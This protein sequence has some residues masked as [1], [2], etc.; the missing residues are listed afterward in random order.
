[1]PYFPFPPRALIAG[2]L[3]PLNLV[4]Q[5]QTVPAP[6]AV[7]PSSN[8]LQNKPVSADLISTDAMDLFRIK[9]INE[10]ALRTP[11]LS[12]TDTGSRSFGDVYSIRGLTSP[13]FFGNPVAT[14]Y[15]DDVPMTD[16]F[17]NVQRLSPLNTVEIRRGPQPLMTGRNA[18]GGL[19]DI[20]TRRPGNSFEGGLDY[21]YGSFN[22][23]SMDAYLMGPVVG[24]QLGFRI[25]GG[26]DNHAGY[27]RNAFTG[28]VVDDQEHW[29]INGGLY[30]K[31]APGWDV[32][33]TASYDEYDDGAPRLTRLDR[34]FGF[35]TT[36]T[37]IKGQQ[38]RRQDSE[39]LRVAYEND[40]IKVLSVTSHRHFG[41]DPYMVDLGFSPAFLGP[42]TL[43]QDMDAW[44]QEFRV[45]NNDKHSNW[46]WN[47]GLFG[48]TSRIDGQRQR[49]F[50]S[51]TSSSNTTFRTVD[52]GFPFLFVPVETITNRFTQFE[53]QRLYKHTLDEKDFAVFAGTSWKGLDPLTFTIGARIDYVQRN[54]V[55]DRTTF[56]KA[57]ITDNTTT[58]IDPTGGFFFFPPTFSTTQS[59]R[60]FR[61]VAPHIDTTDDWS[62]VTPTFGVDWKIN[63]HLLA[64]A[65]TTYGFKP[66]GFNPVADY[67]RFQDFKAEK[68]WSTEV[69]VK[70]EWLGGQL[71]TNMAWF[72]NAIR[73]YQVG[74]AITLS[75][76]AIFNAHRA[77]TYGAEFE[78]RYAICPILDC[79]GAIGWTHAR[80]TDFT[81]PV[82]G[83]TLDGVTPPF[84]PEFNAVVALDLHLGS[85]FFSRVE[86]VATGNTQFDL[87]NRARY[88]QGSYGL[89]NA[90]IGYREKNWSV[91]LYGTNLDNEEYYT[92]MNPKEYTG[93]PGIP[94]EFGVRVGVKF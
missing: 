35:Y 17:A 73:D 37:E 7:A 71:T 89:L 9:E 30:W 74:R 64:Y 8:A 66:G 85:G 41:L 62:H 19:I 44:S 59:V 60:N 40:N 50:R 93:S 15:V 47:A 80:L 32:S 33:F 3:L 51:F 21:E 2:L 22:T 43:S 26:Y 42:Y 34:P 81:D 63:D 67:V 65:K 38:K 27:L 18:Y 53:F 72:Y 92:F 77:T 46:D 90:S 4:C 79:S 75:D 61:S 20:R 49:G 91:S 28:K 14:I 56:G 78:T 55:R 57:Y 39:A 82:S 52:V 25:G 29:G 10:L 45:S 36:M 68:D 86:Y 69:G 12:I 70:G 83:R 1:M 23:H 54:L 94:R 58:I 16:T 76:Y 84:V 6:P 5:G 31:P 87:Y 88:R 48:A 13:G 24:D 11:N